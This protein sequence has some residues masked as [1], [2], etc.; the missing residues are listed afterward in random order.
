MASV[1]NSAL[2]MNYALDSHKC[3]VYL[4]IFV[5]SLPS[6]SCC[7]TQNVYVNQTELACE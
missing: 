2:L 6:S 1:V 3:L 4:A 7:V 5:H